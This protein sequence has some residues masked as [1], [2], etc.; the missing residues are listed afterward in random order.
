MKHQFFDCGEFLKPFSLWKFWKQ[1]EIEDVLVSSARVLFFV[2]WFLWWS[3]FLVVFHALN[4]CDNSFIRKYWFFPATAAVC[5]FFFSLG[6]TCFAVWNSILQFFLA[7]R[8]DLIWSS[9]WVSIL[10][11][12]FLLGWL[13]LRC[14][15][16]FYNFLAKRLDLL[17]SSSWVSILIISSGLF[18]DFVRIWGFISLQ[19]CGIMI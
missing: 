14:E 6:M 12:S 16:V 15:T 1:V 4:D 18:V 11:S 7:K 8:L 9:S 5:V 13:F 2:T 17:W 19:S 10:F 3:V